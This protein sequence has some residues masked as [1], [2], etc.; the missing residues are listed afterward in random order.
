MMAK[1][2]LTNFYIQVSNWLTKEIVYT[3]NFEERVAVAS[4][5]IDIRAVSIIAIPV[6]GYPIFSKHNCCIGDEI[7]QQ[8]C[9]Y[10]CCECCLSVIISVQIKPYNKGI[11]ELQF[12]KEYRQR[13]E[14]VAYRQECVA[15]ITNIGYTTPTRRFSVSLNH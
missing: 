7:S 6:G 5:I 12:P 2:G 9:W 3:E 14:L 1:N 11:Y 13:L 8:F 15:N 4:R 10:V